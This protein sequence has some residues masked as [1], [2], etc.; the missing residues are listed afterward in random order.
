MEAP[1]GLGLNAINGYHSALIIS[2]NVVTAAAALSRSENTVWGNFTM[3][4]KQ[5]VNLPT[6]ILPNSVY[7][8]Q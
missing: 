1:I 7:V 8:K 3:K 2:H 5:V 6:L 4:K